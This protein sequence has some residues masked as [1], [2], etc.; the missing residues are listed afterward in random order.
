MREGAVYHE[1]SR[2]NPLVRDAPERSKDAE[3]AVTEWLTQKVE[4]WEKALDAEPPDM[5][6][7]HDLPSLPGQVSIGAFL[8]ALKM[9]TR[10]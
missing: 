10:G 4:R 2:L 8:D 6:A 7:L 1:G 9:R 5:V 3:E